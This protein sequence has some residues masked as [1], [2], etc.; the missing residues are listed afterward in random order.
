LAIRAQVRPCG[1]SDRFLLPAVTGLGRTA[2]L[3]LFRLHFRA[4]G[5]ATIAQKQSGSKFLRIISKN[6]IKSMKMCFIKID[7]TQKHKPRNNE[8]A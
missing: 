8:D 4:G 5:K 3:L 6:H 2:A 7:P 1:D